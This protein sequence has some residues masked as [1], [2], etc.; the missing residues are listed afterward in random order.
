MYTV[1][2][3]KLHDKP[4]SQDNHDHHASYQELPVYLPRFDKVINNINT[5][6]RK[7]K[8]TSLARLPECDNRKKGYFKEPDFKIG[9]RHRDFT[10]DKLGFNSLVHGPATV[11][12][13]AVKMQF[14][15]GD[16]DAVLYQDPLE[17]KSASYATTHCGHQVSPDRRATILDHNSFS[18]VGQITPDPH[19]MSK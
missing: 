8:A 6:T 16:K 5:E 2:K 13:R 9:S 19:M 11:D 3:N 4:T 18:F 17:P 15:S 10:P 12:T 7:K 14:L 1:V